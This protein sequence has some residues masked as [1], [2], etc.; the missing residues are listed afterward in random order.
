MTKELTKELTKNSVV[1]LV[2]SRGE[3]VALARSMD[4]E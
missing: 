4:R 3:N 2:E 1:L